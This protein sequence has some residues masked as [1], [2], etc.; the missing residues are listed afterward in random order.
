MTSNQENRYSMEVALRNFLN[1]N[2]TIT[3]SLPHFGTSFSDNL[4]KIGIIREQQE[5]DKSGIA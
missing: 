4:D 5:N 1:Q 2:A 3:S